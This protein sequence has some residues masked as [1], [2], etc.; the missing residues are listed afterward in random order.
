MLKL[1]A[2]GYSNNEIAA[3]L[4]ISAHTVKS[5]TIN[6]FN[7]LNVNDRTKA[8]VVAVHRQII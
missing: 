8:A 2:E 7:K 5:H 4:F 3:C 6:I 1:I